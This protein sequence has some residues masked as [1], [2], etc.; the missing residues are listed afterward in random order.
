MHYQRKFIA[1]IIVLLLYPVIGSSQD[2]EYRFTGTDHFNCFMILAGKKTTE[3]GSILIAHNNDLS[4]KEASLIEKIPRQ[5]HKREDMV[6][7]PSGLEIPQTEETY[8]WMVLK[9]FR[10]FYEGDAIAINEYQVSIAGGVALGGD[11][12]RR[13]RI[14]DPLIKT[15]L[16]GGVRYIALQRSRTAR[17]CV[18]IIGKLYSRYGVTYPSGVAV[19]DPDEIWYIESGGGHMWAAVRIPDNAVWVQANG[20]RIGEIDFSDPENYLYAPD[21]KEFSRE[22]GL[23]NPDE[24]SFNFARAF[25]QRNHRAGRGFGNSRRTWRGISLLCPSKNFNPDAKEFPMFIIPDTKI[26]MQKLIEILRD[27]Y[28]EMEFDIYP[29]EG[30]PSNER[31]IAVPQCVHSSILWITESKLPPFGRTQGFAPTKYSFVL[32]LY[33]VV[34]VLSFM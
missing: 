33:F 11:I 6:K 19:A 1:F 23:W 22:K 2:N 26:T 34:A 18:E 7:F 25:G 4:G 12:N 5:K 10:G 21:L 30:P 3:D 27:H 9:I 17:E 29:A 20:Y 8:E 15:G 13:A 14:A 31:A 28:N 16:T 32:F 24:G